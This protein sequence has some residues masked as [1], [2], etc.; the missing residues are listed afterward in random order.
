MYQDLEEKFEDFFGIK[1]TGIAMAPGRLEIL[2]NHTDY[3][4]G[5]VLSAAVKQNTQF[6]LTPCEGNICTIHDFR[7][8]ETVKFDIT[9]IDKASGN[10]TDYIKG[11]ICALR[12]RGIE[13]SAFNG[14]LISEIPLSAGMSSSA[15]I[16]ISVGFAFAK[17]FDIS[18]SKT[19]WAKIGQEVEN[20]YMGLNSG[21]LD[22][23]T[24]VFGEQDKLLL[25]DFR[26]NEA[27]ET[28]PI[29][30]NYVIV[31]V[32]SMV[33][34][35]LVDSDYNNRRVSCENVVA[36]FAKIDK[37][38]KA[39][40]DVSLEF[41]EK[42]KN[43]I[44]HLDYLRVWHVISEIR[45]V[46]AGIEYLKNND[47]KSFGQLLFN[48]HASSKDKFENSCEEL[49]CLVELARSLPGC[50]GSRLSGGG[51]GGITINLV[52][53]K[54]AEEFATRIKTA[55]KLQTDIDTETIICEIGNGAC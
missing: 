22:Q 1:A 41:L 13:I 20:S 30:N 21:L 26:I 18:L 53:K 12:R 4:E 29:P 35:N 44:A 24:S 40:R 2:G 38:I 37:N 50:I 32:N 10:W 8:K 55:Y 43:I 52:E 39:L 25:C 54:K 15:A 48:S 45:N 11:V 47:I 5:V 3:N 17:V 27:V 46:K 51:F 31:V 14:G 36:E 28:I 33:K 7:F 19:E 34:H 16:E 6:A 9:D 49:D 42:N 23:F